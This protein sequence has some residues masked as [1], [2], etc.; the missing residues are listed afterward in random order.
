MSRQKGNV[1]ENLACDFLQANGFEI[2]ERNFFAR[3]GEIDIVAKK[4]G[5]LHFIEVKS[6]KN[7]HPAQ[8]ITPQKLNKIL[9][10]LNRYIATNNITLPFCVDAIIIQ[11]S[12]FCPP[13]IDMIENIS[14]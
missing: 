11:Y 13:Q 14:L 9:L 6:G 12:N 2:V 3:F 1:A 8:N 7:F 4:N 5:I 10:A